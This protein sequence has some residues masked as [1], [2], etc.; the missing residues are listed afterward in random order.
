MSERLFNVWKEFRFDSA[1]HLDAGPDG[2]PK[3]RRMHGHSY[4]VEVWL[5]GPRNAL[6]WVVDMGD[7]ERHLKEVREIL[8]HRLLNEVVGLGAPTME[9][10]ASF[11]WDHIAVLGN[12]Q[13]VV[14][15][16]Q[17]NGEGCEFY[18][19]LENA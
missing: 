17:Q 2:D 10:I 4:Q 3:Y 12:L 14:V 6:G 5:S 11:V 8:D 16:R 9:N 18:G 1:H 7:L 19:P 15:R 13:R